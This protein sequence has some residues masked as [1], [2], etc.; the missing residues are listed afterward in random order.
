MEDRTIQGMIVEMN[1]VSER[2]AKLRERFTSNFMMIKELD[3][4]VHNYRATL[5]RVEKEINDAREKVD[6]VLAEMSDQI[7]K[8]VKVAPPDE[9]GLTLEE[10]DKEYQI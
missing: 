6:S 4:T 9:T 7:L 1:D 3:E 8:K 5:I 2:I 10:L